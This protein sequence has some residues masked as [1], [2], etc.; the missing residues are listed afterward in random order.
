MAGYRFEVSRDLML[1]PSFL[2]KTTEKFIAQIDVN[3]K[4]YIKENY[5]AGLS[6]RTG[7]SYSMVEETFKGKGSSSHHYGW[8]TGR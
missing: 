1:E 5:W 3:A 6:Y 7:G 8:Y 2:F 4:L